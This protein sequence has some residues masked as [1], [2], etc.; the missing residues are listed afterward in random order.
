MM[1][2]HGYSDKQELA[3]TSP[4]GSMSPTRIELVAPRMEEKDE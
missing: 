3:H 1:T 2:K 4:D